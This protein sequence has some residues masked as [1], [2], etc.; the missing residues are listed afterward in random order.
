MSQLTLYVTQNIQ[1]GENIKYCWQV[2][3]FWIW[4][5]KYQQHSGRGINISR[6]WT[7][8]KKKKEQNVKL[9]NKERVGG[10]GYYWSFISFF[11]LFMDQTVYEVWEFI[12]G[13]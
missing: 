9:C 10:G 5:K 2:L 8:K 12:I 4:K 7:S 13:L 6:I 1:G 3:I 11:F